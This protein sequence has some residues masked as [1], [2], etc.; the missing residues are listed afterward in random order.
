MKC[1]LKRTAGSALRL[2]PPPPPPLQAAT[3]PFHRG[4]SQAPPAELSFLRRCSSFHTS[5]RRRP[6]PEL[7]HFARRRRGEGEGE[8]GGR[9]PWYLSW[10]KLLTRALAPAAA[11]CALYRLSLQ[12]VPYTHRRRAVVLPARYERK[13]GER[14]FQALKEKAAAA[15]K[16]LLL[17]DDAESRDEPRGAPEPE[18][19][20]K[21]LVGLDWE[22]IVVEDDEASASCLPGGKIVVNTGF[23]RRFQT[24]A[25]IAVVL[26]REVGHIVA[27][28]AAEGFSKAL[29]SELLS[30]CLWGVF[31]CR[32]FVARTLPLL[33]VK[34]HFSRK[35][36][37]EAD[38]IG[39]MLLA[40]AGFDPHVAL[41][42]H[43]K[44][45]DLGGESELRNYLSTHPSRR[46][47]VQNLSQHKLM[48][49]A[50]ELYRETNA[51][52]TANVYSCF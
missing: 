38:H 19:M 9:I 12:T 17:D 40:A 22:V 32:D 27:R 18:P 51:R 15:G 26:G 41:E 16:L 29:W 8:G 37:I 43:K 21:H 10:E 48:E 46:K 2:L 6:E 13:L 36:E 44:L 1:I 45:R 35:M 42:V 52:K 4:G 34:R 23:L 14:R 5:A 7:I 28:H 3:R 11:A 31:D 24:D 50:M 33:L 39:I 49:E 25:E 20:T 47:R 30:I